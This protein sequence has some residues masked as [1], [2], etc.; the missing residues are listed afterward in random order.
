MS[1]SR[2]NVSASQEPIIMTTQGRLIATT[3]LMPPSTRRSGTP[4]RARAVSRWITGLLGALLLG[5]APLSAAAAAAPADGRP[6][7]GP[8]VIDVPALDAKVVPG[9]PDSLGAEVVQAGGSPNEEI[10]YYAYDAIGS[11]RMVFDAAGTVVG[12]A[13]Y[14]PFGTEIA[15][16]TGMPAPRFTG[17][18]RDHEAGLDYFNAR[19]YMYR[20]GR[21]STPDP[22]S[23]KIGSPQSW[24]RY[25][26]SLNNGLSFTDP[27]GLQA[28]APCTS[29]SPIA[30]NGVYPTDCVFQMGTEGDPWGGWGGGGGGSSYW[31]PPSVGCPFC[32]SVFQRTNPEESGYYWGGGGTV[33][34]NGG[35]ETPPVTGGPTPPPPPPPVPPTPPTTCAPET[36]VTEVA[37]DFTFISFSVSGALGIWEQSRSD[38]NLHWPRG[39]L[40][41]TGAFGGSGVDTKN[42]SLGI[43][44][45]ASANYTFA[46]LDPDKFFNGTGVNASFGRAGVGG[47]GLVTSDGKIVGATAGYG[48]G[49]SARLSTRVGGTTRLVEWGSCAQ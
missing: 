48:P 42:P 1:A 33:A 17:Q 25:A 6:D 38:W 49:T 20:A 21:F 30:V 46:H 10:E 19:S 35:V 16:T 2:R 23:G 28:A 8:A 4:R 34:G 7:R 13:T 3:A 14:N 39:G 15:G 9:A 11:V 36:R 47:A 26:Y 40:V 43:G 31:I 27:S 32:G 24:N 5:I 29:V 18:V 12:Q 44:A 45:G 22:L 41:F 37:V